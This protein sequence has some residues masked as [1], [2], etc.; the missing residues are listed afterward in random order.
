MGKGLPDGRGE[1]EPNK[2]AHEWIM[3][4]SFDST[5]L[6]YTW[7]DSLSMIRNDNNAMKCCDKQIQVKAYYFYVLYFKTKRR[8]LII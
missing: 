4:G 2:F 3:H 1:R 7:M 6:L 5:D 8:M